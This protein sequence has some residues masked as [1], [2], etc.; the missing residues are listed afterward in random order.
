[1]VGRLSPRK[2]VD[3][4]LDDVGLLRRS[5][6][7]A[8]L[9]VCGSVFPGYEW[10]EGE[11]R[12]RAA[13]PDLDG[14]V[15]LLGYVRPTWP[16]LEAADAVVVPSRAEPFGNTAVEAMH[17]ARPLV[18]SRV[19]GLAEVVTDEVTGLLVPADDAEALAEAL[20]S[21]ATDP[22]LATRLAEQG[23]R[24]AAE[25]FSV[26]GYRATMARIVGELLGR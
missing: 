3:V 24:E 23:E 12:E 2:G 17:A 22:D 1:M 18:A 25:R 8:S 20:G 21:L 26:V 5:G 15:E 4:A 11:L 6:V 16:V 10:Y 13:Q 7:D 14:H 19:Q 9:S